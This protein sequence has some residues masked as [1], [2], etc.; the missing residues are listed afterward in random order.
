MDR[1][2]LAYEEVRYLLD[3]QGKRVLGCRWDEAGHLPAGDQ[4]LYKL[5][6]RWVLL[7]KSVAEVN[8]EWALTFD[9]ETKARSA[10]MRWHGGALVRIPTDGG[11]A[12]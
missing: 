5:R 11:C 12:R 2:E 9:K 6:G 3:T 8:E 7:G 1:N 10:Y 4:V